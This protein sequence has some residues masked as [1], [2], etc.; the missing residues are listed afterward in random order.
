MASYLKDKKIELLRK[1]EEQVEKRITVLW[2][3]YRQASSN[4]KYTAMTY[5]YQIDAIFVINYR[6]D[7]NPLTDVIKFRG[8]K[9]AITSVD[10]YEGGKKDLKIMARY[11][12]R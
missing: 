6:E 1:D 12:G 3:Y 2:A 5:K 10:D 9:Y 7:I 8:K 11:I 4:E